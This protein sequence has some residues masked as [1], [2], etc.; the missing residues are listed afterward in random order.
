MTSIPDRAKPMGK[1][2]RVQLS[3][4]G[5][6][7]RTGPTVRSRRWLRKAPM[8]GR[9]DRGQG[10]SAGRSSAKKGAMAA[11]NLAS[12]AP[13]HPIAFSTK[14]I[15]QDRQQ[16][17]PAP[18]PDVKRKGERAHDGK[19]QRQRHD[20]LVRDLH[21]LHVAPRHPDRDRQDEGQ[22]PQCGGGGRMDHPCTFASQG[23]EAAGGGFEILRMGV[24][25]VFHQ[26]LA[27]RDIALLHGGKP[28]R[29]K[30]FGP[31]GLGHL[32]DRQVVL[33]LRRRGRGRG[34]SWW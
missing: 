19:D 33:A 21:E 16:M 6:T 9:G 24:D 7:E 22:K 23:L 13:S 12:P 3:Q 30:Q 14:P 34:C 5:V 11:A 27:D 25:G 28:Q 17:R 31:L 20:R 10:R 18:G 29:V 4:S 1:S 32:D 8:H 2:L 26:R 15:A